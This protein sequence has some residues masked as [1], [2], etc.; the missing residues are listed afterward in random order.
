[1]MAVVVVVVTAVVIVVVDLAGTA[2]PA[3]MMAQIVHF[4]WNTISRLVIF[5]LI[6]S[7]THFVTVRLL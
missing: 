2:I 1:M 3:M 7:E 4:G 5:I 6:I